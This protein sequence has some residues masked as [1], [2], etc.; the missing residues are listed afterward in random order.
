MNRQCVTVQQTNQSKAIADITRAVTQT[1]Q[2]P[3]NTPWSMG[4][5][6]PVRPEL[7]QAT[8]AR[9][10]TA[11][12]AA[13]GDN[14]TMLDPL[15]ESLSRLVDETAVQ[16]NPTA[17]RLLEFFEVNRR[18]VDSMPCGQAHFGLCEHLD[19]AILPKAFAMAKLLSTYTS[20]AIPKYREGKVC[21]AFRSDSHVCYCF[22]GKVRRIPASQGYV[23]HAIEG[24]DIVS[25][26]TNPYTSPLLAIHRVQDATLP[27]VLT[28]HEHSVAPLDGY[29]G[30]CNAFGL[31]RALFTADSTSWEVS[32][33]ATKAIGPERVEVLGDVVQ[34]IGVVREGVVVEQFQAHDDLT[35]ALAMLKRTVKAKNTP[36]E[37]AASGAGP[38]ANGD[39]GS[40]DKCD[41]PEGYAKPDIRNLPRVA[42]PQAATG[43]VAKLKACYDDLFIADNDY[44]QELL[45]T[46]R[47]EL[48]RDDE[49]D[50]A[51]TKLAVHPPQTGNSRKQPKRTKS[52]KFVAPTVEAA[53]S[54][55]ALAVQA[56]IP[57]I[58]FVE[59]SHL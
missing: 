32:L 19:A 47:E 48:Q 43:M 21:F 36:S 11:A 15:K 31:A 10:L 4:S 28:L 51:L 45:T 29:I 37:S 5:D 9:L 35:S 7:I 44:E 27:F 26:P 41:V 56:T 54:F 6:W 46:I 12:Q 58:S 13:G 24:K 14:K 39:C 25:M 20:K 42:N 22:Q 57:S 1:A 18:I 3:E 52:A 34:K 49:I 40:N 53:S 50:E 33:V 17:Q 59:V 8:R 2:H 16:Q 38:S 55:V 23:S 30:A